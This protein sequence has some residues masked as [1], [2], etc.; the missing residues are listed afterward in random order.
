MDTGKKQPLYSVIMESLR[1]EIQQGRLKP[2]DKLLTEQ[3]LAEKYDVSRITSK[4]ALEELE[5]AGLIYRVRGSGSFVADRI[6][7]EIGK[8]APTLNVIALLLPFGSSKGGGVDLIHGIENVAQKND[9]YLS[10]HNTNRTWQ[11]ERQLILKLIHDGV[12]GIILYPFSTVGNLDLLNILAHN[13]YPIVMIDKYIHDLPINSVVSDNFLGSYQITEYLIK[14]GHSKIAFIS[15][16]SID[17][18][19]SLRERYLGYCKAMTD[20]SIPLTVDNIISSYMSLVPNEKLCHDLI[21]QSVE[22]KDIGFFTQFLQN[23]FK[24]QNITALE[25]SKDYIASCLMKAAKTI[26]ICVPED[27]SIVGFDN[28]DLS[29]LLEVPLTTMNQDFYRMGEKA[30]EIVLNKIRNPRSEYQKVVIPVEMIVRKSVQ[31]I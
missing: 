5:H 22:D 18:S 23:L 3:E 14:S 25:A 12:K 29:A 27:L 19:S 8:K 2:G 7:G 16:D 30:A 13:N 21:D 9:Y 1:Q 11:N 10:I 24:N 15:D 17:M 20:Y 6:S 4:R 31:K 28:L 26:G